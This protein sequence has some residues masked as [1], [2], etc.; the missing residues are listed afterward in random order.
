VG[1]AGG[2]AGVGRGHPLHAADIVA[3]EVVGVVLSR[4]A[5]A[6][7]QEVELGG[8]EGEDAVWRKCLSSS[9]CAC[10]G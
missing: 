4:R 7:G 2:A 9:V 1:A 10:K 6:G 3:V 8:G 5:G